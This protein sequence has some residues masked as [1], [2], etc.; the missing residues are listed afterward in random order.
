L[1]RFRPPR[2][3]FEGSSDDHSRSSPG[4]SCMLQVYVIHIC[5]WHTQSR[6]TS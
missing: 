5:V 4:G 2:R 1:S 3:P 6:S